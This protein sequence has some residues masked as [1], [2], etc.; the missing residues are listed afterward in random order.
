[1][2]L[3]QDDVVLLTGAGSGLGLGVARHFIAE[4]AQLVILEI[5]PEKVEQLRSEFGEK[6][7][8]LQGDVT[9]VEDL[10]NCRDAIMK[11]HGRLNALV[12]FQGIFDG[13]IPLKDIPLEKLDKLFLEMFSTNVQGY[14]LSAKIFLD[15]LEASEGAMVLTASTAAFAA[16]GGGVMYTATKGAVRSLVNQLSFEF[17]PK[18]RVNGVAPAGIAKSQLRG[19]ASLGLQD[20]KQSD[21]PLDLVLSMIKKIM[22]LQHLPAAEE[23]GPLYALLASR[24][25]R[26]MTGQMVVADQGLL[27]RAVIS[28]V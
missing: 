7:L 28:T 25:N 4:G 16:D 13:N 11:R 19:P 24:Q 14:I 9:R 20:S 1:M 17:S 10:L 3:L 27:N 21:M 6:V 26:V 5:V 23:Y 8:V 2:N 15:L 12:G 22:P 18:I